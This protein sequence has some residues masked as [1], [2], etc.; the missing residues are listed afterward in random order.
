VWVCPSCTEGTNREDGW[1]LLSWN[2]NGFLVHYTLRKVP[3]SVVLIDIGKRLCT[4][5][6]F[7]SVFIIKYLLKSR[8]F[9]PLVPGILPETQEINGNCVQKLLL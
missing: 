5:L 7:P 1:A 8:E 2:V 6:I 3:E 9:F 4:L